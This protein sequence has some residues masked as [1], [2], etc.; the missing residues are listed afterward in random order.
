MM[1]RYIIKCD[2]SYYSERLNG[3]VNTKG[4]ASKFKSLE[5]A[6]KY[7]VVAKELCGD[8]K[9]SLIRVVEEEVVVTDN[10]IQELI[11]LKNK[12]LQ[13]GNRLIEEMI[14]KDISYINNYPRYMPSFDEFIYD[15]YDIDF[16]QEA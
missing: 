13:Y 12:F 3:M 15:M 5:E 6:K 4:M 1:E 16:E 8:K 9:V 2:R 10:E 14:N 11:Y 7:Y